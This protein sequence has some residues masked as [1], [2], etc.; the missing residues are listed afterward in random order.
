M[1]LD[2]FVYFL[3][4]CLVAFCCWMKWLTRLHDLCFAQGRFQLLNQRIMMSLIPAN[5]FS[6]GWIGS[7][8]R[9]CAI[10][11]PYRLLPLTVER[12]AIIGV[13]GTLYLLRHVSKFMRAVHI[14]KTHCIN[15]YL[16]FSVNL[17]SRHLHR[18]HNTGFIPY[19]IYT[20]IYTCIMWI[21]A[22]TYAYINRFRLCIWIYMYLHVYRS[23][24]R[25]Q[26]FKHYY[27]FL[28]N[29]YVY[30]NKYIW[31][32]NIYIYIDTNWEL[33]ASNKAE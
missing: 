24:C 14:C 11:V 16:N 28:E 23:P 18:S 22:N 26:H 10:G 29:V 6:I 15:L 17:Q 5:I 27:N 30:R 9:E 2:F 20:H 8:N 7:I 1:F 25:M 3:L 21:Y 32:D 33:W 13:L 4:R 12:W 31:I 19:Y